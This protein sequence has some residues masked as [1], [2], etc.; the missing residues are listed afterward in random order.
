MSFCRL[1][2]PPISG[3]IS[4]VSANKPVSNALIHYRM[5]LCA[6]IDVTAMMLPP[7]PVP[8]SDTLVASAAHDGNAE[9]PDATV[10]DVKPAIMIKS[11]AAGK[12]CANDAEPFDAIAAIVR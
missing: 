4:H 9:A 6:T 7:T 12:A 10:A 1:I 5:M 2:G 3:S 8:N 11:G